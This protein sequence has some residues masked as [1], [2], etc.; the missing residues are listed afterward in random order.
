MRILRYVRAPPSAAPARAR[1]L[2]LV[3]I[4][5]VIALDFN[6]EDMQFIVYLRDQFQ[7][8]G[9]QTPLRQKE[10][11]TRLRALG[12]TLG[13]GMSRERKLI[14][15]KLANGQPYAVRLLEQTSQG[16]L[17]TP[18]LKHYA[19]LFRETLQRLGGAGPDSSVR[20]SQLRVGVINAVTTN[21]LPRV[22]TE[23]DFFQQFPNVDLE[24]VEGE[25]HE[26]ATIVLP[27]VE[28]AIGPRDLLPT[29][30]NCDTFCRR[31]RVLL[32]NP[33]VERQ[34]RFRDVKNVTQL[35]EW[36]RDETLIVPPQRIMPRLGRFLKPMRNGRLITLPQAA[37]RRLWVERG[38]GVA[39]THEE[40]RRPDAPPD[41]LATIDLGDELGWTEVAFVTQD[42]REP[43][44]AGCRLMQSIRAIF[45][46]TMTDPLP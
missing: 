15:T 1:H 42:D 17:P 43:S 28:F 31:K 8:A 16:Y 25:P 29:G 36:L 13:N 5:L 9:D 45:G 22:L 12:L 44:E 27:S 21:L 24:F 46:E 23:S 10:L 39:I 33:A 26:L 32:Y 6:V 41:P 19:E 20:R 2:P 35:R 38:V 37:A 40:R 11:Q 14:E 30:C 4:P 34:R 18:T 3:R 7:A